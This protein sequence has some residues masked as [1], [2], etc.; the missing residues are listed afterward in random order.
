METIGLSSPFPFAIHAAVAGPEVD[1]AMGQNDNPGKADFFATL[2]AMAG[3][4]LRQPLQ[5]ITSAHDILGRI[6]HS[7]EQREE[8]S[9]AQDATRRLA[10]MLGQLVEALELHERSSDH[11]RVPVRLRPI[12]DE[13]VAEFAE[14]ARLKGI[15]LRVSAAR[16]MALSHPVLL[17]GILRNL[18]RNAIDYTPS[19]GSV[20][21]GSRRFGSEVRIAV[22]D[23]GVGIPANALS[24]IFRAF[25][26]GDQS[27]T[28][29]LGLGLFIVKHAADL[30]GH[31]VEVRSAEGRGSC[32]TIVSSAVW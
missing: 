19:G 22:H 5:M 9:Q 23:S 4:D 7:G 6:V 27:N 32:F 2:L 15:M 20:S 1:M 14:P 11:L 26:R 8:L 28:D 29:G 30:L 24:M 10:S 31:R 17:G 12:L 25:Q 18:I 13:I 3:H 21:V 16:G